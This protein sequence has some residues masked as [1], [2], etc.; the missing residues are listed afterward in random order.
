V[1]AIRQRSLEF[2]FWDMGG[3]NPRDAMF[4]D[5]LVRL[6]TPLPGVDRGPFA[7]TFNSDGSLFLCSGPWP[8]GLGRCAFAVAIG[9]RLPWQ[10][11]RG[12]TNGKDPCN[13]EDTNELPLV[14][15]GA[16]PTDR[17]PRRALYIVGEDGAVARCD[18][19]HGLAWLARWLCRPLL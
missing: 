9:V 6:S 15:S 19:S 8:G 11:Q 16:H 17:L 1:L 12:W 18:L 10:M 7:M 2:K 3:K 13:P 14:L 4:R 5:V